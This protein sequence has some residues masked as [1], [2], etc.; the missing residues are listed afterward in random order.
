MGAPLL[1]AL[2]S[3]LN[4][5]LAVLHGRP[6]LLFPPKSCQLMFAE[7]LV[8]KRPT[9]SVQPEGERGSTQL[10]RGAF[11]DPGAVVCAFMPVTN[12][13]STPVTV[14]VNERGLPS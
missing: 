4:N 14:A 9:L 13:L 8:G 3:A 11:T 5:T 7:P 12:E 10:N 2:P 6:L 1:V